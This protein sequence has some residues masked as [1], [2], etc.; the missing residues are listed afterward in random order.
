MWKNYLKI[1]LRNFW[2]QRL[3]SLINVFGL[4]IGLAAGIFIFLYVQDELS[5]DQIHSKGDRIYR[6]TET[7]KNGDDVTTTA[8]TPYKIAPLLAEASPAVEA[9]TRLD[10]DAGRGETQIIKYGD[11]K[12][13]TQAITFA[14]S[15][16][17]EVFSFPLLQGNAKTVLTN[18]NTV[19]LSKTQASLIFD[20]EDPMGKVIAIKDSYSNNSYDAVVTGIMKD[21]PHNVHFHYDIL[22]SKAT[23]DIIIP[24]R[25]DHW[26]W[27]SQ[28]SYI[29]LKE[30]HDIAEVES[31]M[32]EVKKKNAPD[33]FNEWCSFGTQALTDIHL[34]SNLK[35]EIEMN[36]NISNIYIFSI[37]GIF[38]LLIAS[39]NYMNL[40][41][42]RAASRAREVGMRKVIGAQ[43]RQ[44]VRQFL[45]ESMLITFLAFVVALL[46]ANLLL[47]L[48]NNLTGK[49]L[50][51]NDVVKPNMLLIWIGISI[52]IGLIAGSYP[53]FFMASFKPIKVLKG[54]FSKTGSQ[55][56]IL[57]KALV[58]IQFSISI[59]L[60]VGILVIFSQWEYLRTKRLGINTEQ[61]LM[62]PIRSQRVLNNYQT[63]KQE[64]QRTPGVLGVTAT[65]KTPVSVFSNYNVFDVTKEDDDYTLPIIGIDEDFT[66]IYSAEIVEGRAFR[67]FQLDSNSVLLNEA[68]VKL[69]G[70]ENPIGQILKFGNTYQPTVVGVL[71]DFNFESLHKRDSANAFLPDHR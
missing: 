51:F 39:I 64:I 32:A 57:R 8:M 37:I 25:M 54:L 26:G 47:P 40:A 71:K 48:F 17:F 9:F 56:L 19:V 16:F 45:V 44:L 11:K 58:V 36:G 24:Q 55:T 22:V 30:G 50:A 65:S 7:F 31:V 21:M 33:W 70:I 13:E 18:P 20:Q 15:N 34:H 6:L 59:A 43:Y 62:L 4:A 27:T 60:I 1:A 28:Y 35:D 41:T 38:I 69:I 23:G 66:N 49:T 5:Y 46:L 2:N 68:A 10:T 52:V 12:I 61:M 42:A 29:I 14:D 53:A 3:Y 67:N 63:L